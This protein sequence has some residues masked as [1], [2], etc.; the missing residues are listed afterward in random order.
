MKTN[1]LLF[2]LLF[3]LLSNTSCKRLTSCEKNFI[4]GTKISKRAYLVIMDSDG[5][6]SKEE[7]WDLACA[8]QYELSIREKYATVLK[9]AETLERCSK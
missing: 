7:L 2:G 3:I 4:E 6:M 8:S 5:K 1:Q 9:A